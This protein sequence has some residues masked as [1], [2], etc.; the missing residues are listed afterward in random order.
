[1][2]KVNAL[3]DGALVALAALEAA[4]KGSTLQELNAVATAPIASAHLTALA[5]RGLVTSEKVEKEVVSV[6]TVN[7]YTITDE[8][9]NYEQPAA[10]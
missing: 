8:G 2:A 5:R 10:E 1:M 7:A 9:I 6:R 4:P 3:S